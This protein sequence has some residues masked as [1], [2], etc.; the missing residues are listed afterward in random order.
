MSGCC[1]DMR[2]FDASIYGN[3]C[4]IVVYLRWP[5]DKIKALKVLV[6]V[7]IRERRRRMKTNST[8]EMIDYPRTREEE[9]V[10]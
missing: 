9:R 7:F 10:M 6:K 3:S 1:S 4:V 8:R 5:E 2:F